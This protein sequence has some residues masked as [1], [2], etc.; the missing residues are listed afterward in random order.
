[1]W[2]KEEHT[3][4]D[5]TIKDIFGDSVKYQIS[6]QSSMSIQTKD[7]NIRGNIPSLEDASHKYGKQ[8]PYSLYIEKI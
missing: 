8:M 4:L 6:I 7:I 2:T 1:M 3:R 5:S